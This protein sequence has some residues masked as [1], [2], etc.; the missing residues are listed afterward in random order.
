MLSLVVTLSVHAGLVYGLWSACK[1]QTLVRWALNS[2]ETSMNCS[3]PPQVMESTI[4]SL[5]R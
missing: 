3:S 1:A 5:G 2:Y 4:F